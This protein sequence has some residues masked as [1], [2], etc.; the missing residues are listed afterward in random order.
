MNLLY[1]YDCFLEDNFF[2][3]ELFHVLDTNHVPN[4][5]NQIISGAS[6]ANEVS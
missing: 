1:G 2:E 3:V 4:R 5:L 6:F